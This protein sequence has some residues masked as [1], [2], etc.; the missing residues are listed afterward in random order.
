MKATS[1]PLPRYVFIGIWVIASVFL[2]WQ[3][4]QGGYSFDSRFN[5]LNLIVMLLCTAM[6]LV[7]LPNPIRDVPAQ[8]PTKK[9]LFVALIL[10]SAGIL[11]LLPTQVA[12]ALLFVLPAIAL[13]T[14]ILLRQPVKKRES[15]YALILALLAGVTGLGARWITWTRPAVWAILQLFLVLTSLLT[16]WSIFQY[17]GLRQ[18]GVGKTRF[19]CDGAIAA[20]KAFVGGLLLS[21]PWAFLNVLAGGSDHETWVKVW[22]QPVIALQPG[23]AEEAWGRILLVPLLFLLLRR[24]SQSRT[25]FTAALYIMAYWFAYLHTSGG[26]DEIVSTVIIGTLYALPVSYLCLYHDLETAIGWHFGVDFVKFV[27]A[28]ILFNK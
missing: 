16:G 13:V 19:L 28:F 24:V 21:V 27:F 26:L 14:L 10:L 18:Q 1:E 2:G 6:L 4:G 7:L 8:K 5:V 3:L 17:T 12:R 11:F 22:W 25:A 15:L 20:L 9:V 23:I